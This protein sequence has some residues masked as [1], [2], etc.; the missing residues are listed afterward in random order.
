MLLRDRLLAKLAA[1]LDRERT[2]RYLRRTDTPN[3][4]TKLVALYQSLDD[5]DD[6]LADVD[7][8]LRD[9]DIEEARSLIHMGRESIAA[10]I[11]EL[12]ELL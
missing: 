9:G 3:G 5:A 7:R 10:H 6:S 8:A 2:A 12:R 1:W 4:D 11:A